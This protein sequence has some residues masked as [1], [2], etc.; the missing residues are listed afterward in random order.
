MYRLKG[1]GFRVWGMGLRFRVKVVVWDLG[2]AAVQV[3]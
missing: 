2:L 3:C 1:L